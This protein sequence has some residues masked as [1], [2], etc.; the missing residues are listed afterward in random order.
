MKKIF[1]PILVVLIFAFFVPSVNAQ[2]SPSIG[3]Y[4]GLNFANASVTPT[5][6]T[7][8]RTCLKVGAFADLSFS[9]IISLQPGLEY[10][11]KGT[12]YTT[13]GYTITWKFGYLEVPVLLKIKFDLQEVKP[14]VFAGPSFGIN[15]SATEDWSGGNQSGSNDIKNNLETIDFGLRFGAGTDFKI[16]TKIKLFVNALYS[17]GLSNIVKTPT[18]VTVK[19][20]GFQIESGVKFGL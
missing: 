11:A 15:L 12:E 17:I 4:V 16:D 2:L 18:T 7:S 6:T 5:Q 19:N 1:V 10:I 14:Y 8:T 3:G 13:Q 20:N 9:P